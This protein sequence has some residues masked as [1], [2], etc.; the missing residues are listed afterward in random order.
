MCCIF[1]GA[2]YHTTAS[3]VAPAVTG[4]AQ[5]GPHAV[6]R[7]DPSLVQAAFVEAI[8]WEAPAHR[9][10]R[11]AKVDVELAGAQ[12]RG[13]DLVW[14]VVGAANR[15]PSV[16]ERPHDFDA[17]R[18]PK[19]QLAL[20][21]GPHY[22]VGAGLGRIEHV[23]LVTLLL[24]RFPDLRLRDDW[25]PQWA[26]FPSNRFLASLPVELEPAATSSSRAA[27]SPSAP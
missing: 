23:T 26:R 19:G 5:A 9:L 27:P 3:S 20:G 8:R 18:E 24:E 10:A 14:V 2:A 17:L 22:C 11:R 16:Y 21:H 15:D 6:V 25:T 13:G 7:A 12:I 1:L 4:L